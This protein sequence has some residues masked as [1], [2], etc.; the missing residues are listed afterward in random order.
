MRR[1]GQN[2]AVLFDIVDCS[3]GR[4]NHGA[5]IGCLS[6]GEGHVAKVGKRNHRAILQEIL[7]DPL[8]ILLAK[9]ALG[10]R[11][12]EGVGFRLPSGQIIDSGGAAHRRSG[13][14]SQLDHIPGGDREAVEIIGKVRVPFVPS[15]V[16]RLSIL[17]AKVDS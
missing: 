6:V 17:D 1:V 11:E 4:A 5:V 3:T 2:I 8:C 10:T 9:W 7:N 16:R 12:S 13:M 15:A 14:H